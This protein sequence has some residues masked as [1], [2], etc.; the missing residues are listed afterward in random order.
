MHITI[1]DPETGEIQGVLCID[2]G[3]G[4]CFVLDAQ[5]EVLDVLVATA[6]AT[7]VPGVTLVVPQE[8]VPELTELG[9]HVD[10]DQVVLVKE[11]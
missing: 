3:A 1:T 8:A 10:Q 4:T 6:K 5:L 7:N 11:G 9:W 2:R